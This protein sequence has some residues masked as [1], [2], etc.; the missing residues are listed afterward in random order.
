MVRSRA[1]RRAARKSQLA[2]NVLAATLSRAAASPVNSSGLDYHGVRDSREYVHDMQCRAAS[3]D[4]ASVDEAIK[5]KT[6]M[7]RATLTTENPVRVYDWRSGQVI[8]EV[9]TSDGGQFPP[10]LPLFDDHFA[11]TGRQL[12]SVR[13]IKKGNGE[14]SGELH[15]ASNAGELI[16]QRW[17]MVEQRHI[18][19]VSIGYVYGEGDY[20]DI[21][22]GQSAK[23]QGREYKAGP[24]TLRV[25]TRWRA[26][27]TSITSIGADEMAKIRKA[28]N[29]TDAHR[30]QNSTSAQPGG[31]SESVQSHKVGS[32]NKKLRSF[33]EKCGLR[34]EV[35]DDQAWNFY[36][37]MGGQFRTDADA[38]IAEEKIQVPSE[39]SDTAD[40][41]DPADTSDPD[42]DDDATPAGVRS[43][44]RR[45]TPGVRS[46]R[47]SNEAEVRRQERERV[48]HIESYRGEVWTI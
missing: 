1:K 24:V 10:Q 40:E 12:G 13:A 47:R 15:F 36:R 33:L 7:I 29:A 46:Q 9:L 18:T 28:N 14:H 31:D 44:S 34:S 45:P 30:L 43:S 6:R 25:V 20:V 11:S 26:K 38:I 3:V 41:T 21:K 23:I 35:G 48:S 2:K 39:R 17:A 37:M 8:E 22:P 5:S 19:D 32:M 4:M 27:E 42:D 16:D